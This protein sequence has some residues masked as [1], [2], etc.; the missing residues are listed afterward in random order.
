MSYE[1]VSGTF[2][3]YNAAP[4]QL[5]CFLLCQPVHDQQLIERVHQ[6]SQPAIARIT[7]CAYLKRRLRKLPVD[8]QPLIGLAPERGNPKVKPEARPLLVK[9]P[10]ASGIENRVRRV[11]RQVSNPLDLNRNIGILTTGPE[12]S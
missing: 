4:V 9:E 6:R 12:K 1:Q 7:T 10:R 11:Q 3:P 5:N 2:L 8:Q